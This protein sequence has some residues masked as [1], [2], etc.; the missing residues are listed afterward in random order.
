MLAI[1]VIL[2]LLW[3]GVPEMLLGKAYAVNATATAFIGLSLLLLSN[4]LTWDD[5]L[6]EKKC[7]GHHYLVWCFNHDG[8]LFEQIGRD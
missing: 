5:I 7:L 3:A 8:N 1:F 2:L 4:V 6:K